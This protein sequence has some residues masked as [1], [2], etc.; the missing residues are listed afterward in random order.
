MCHQEGKKEGGKKEGII[1]L[2][3]IQYPVSQLQGG[4]KTKTHQRPPPP[5]SDKVVV[6][7]VVI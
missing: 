3:F 6:D 1:S 7:T 2:F 4:R 5:N